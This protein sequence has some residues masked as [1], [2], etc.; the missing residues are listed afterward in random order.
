MEHLATPQDFDPNKVDPINPNDEPGAA[1]DRPKTPDDGISDEGSTAKDLDGES[2]E[3]TNANER[4]IPELN[5]DRN[6]VENQDP[7]PFDIDESTG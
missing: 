7:T 4:E 2:Q 5:P 1:N 3:S 6:D